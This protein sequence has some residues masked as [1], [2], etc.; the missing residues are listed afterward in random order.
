MPIRTLLLAF[1][2]VYRVVFTL[3]SLQAQ[4]VCCWY[5]W[6]TPYFNGH[7]LAELVEVKVLTS[8][9]MSAMHCPLTCDSEEAVT[10]H[11]V[12]FFPW[13]S[14]LKCF[15]VLITMAGHQKHRRFIMKMAN[16]K[17]LV[18]LLGMSLRFLL[19]EGPSRLSS[20]ALLQFDQSLLKVVSQC[21][22]TFANIYS[23][24]LDILLFIYI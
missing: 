18:L 13:C 15:L 20:M 17:H 9:C 8:V 2:A 16:R 19:A 11:P 14:V 6:S 5:H 24:N 10:H 1:T 3:Y 7:L 22:C 12:D 21:T 23:K 4:H